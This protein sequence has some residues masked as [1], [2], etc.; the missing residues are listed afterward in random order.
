MKSSFFLSVEVVPPAG[1]D[2]SKLLDLLRGVKD[3]P[4]TSLSIA[5]NPVAKPKLSPLAL[6]VLAKRDL[7]L[8]SVIHITTRDHNRL[9]LQSLLWSVKTLEARGILAASGDMISPEARK[10]TSH[11][12][13]IDVYELISLAHGLGITTGAVVT[14]YPDPKAYKREEERLE[15]KRDAG[16]DYAVTQPVYSMEDAERVVKTSEKLG[17]PIV[18]GI[19]PLVTEKHALFLKEKVG[20]IFVP[21]SVVSAMGGPAD[22]EDHGIKISRELLAFAKGHLAGACI[23]PPFNRFYLVK[24]I[25][26][27]A[28]TE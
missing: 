16:A 13:D 27:Q 14:P 18:L 11:V 8:D 3:L 15:R 17:L 24:K 21:D 25:L 28:Q 2:C 9:S 12:K 26:S 4:I 1:P 20:G 5:T 6:A 22:P 10:S 23:M 7:Y 19:L